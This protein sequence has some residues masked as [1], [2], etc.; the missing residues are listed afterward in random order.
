MG[1]RLHELHASTIH[2]PLALLPAA[3]TFDLL[4]AL[5]NDRSLGRTGLRLWWAGVGGAL[6]AELSGLAASQEVRA[7]EKKHRD[8]ML[9]HGWGN[10]LVGLGALGLALW[11][12]TRPPTIASAIIGLTACTAALFTAYLGGEMVY[13]GGL[14]VKPAGGV[15]DSPDVLSVKAPGRF[16]KDAGKGLGWAVREGARALRRG[17]PSEALHI[18]EP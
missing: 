9:I 4:A 15:L 5:K 6:V 14:G 11:R 8:A 17:P 7:Y 2:A 12:R 16:V 3:A 1:M 18:S 10:T 13:S